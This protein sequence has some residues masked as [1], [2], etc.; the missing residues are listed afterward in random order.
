MARSAKNSTAPCV[1]LV[2]ANFID[3]GKGAWNLLL[4][5]ALFLALATPKARSLSTRGDV[6]LGP[7]LLRVDDHGV[8]LWVEY[9][10][11]LIVTEL[12]ARGRPTGTVA[13]PLPDPE[14]HVLDI[15]PIWSGN[16]IAVFVL[17]QGFSRID[18]PSPYRRLYLMPLTSHAP[19]LVPVAWSM[20]EDGQADGLVGAGV[21]THARRPAVL[22]QKRIAKT[23]HPRQASVLSIVSEGQVTEHLQVGDHLVATSITWPGDGAAIMAGHDDGHP[24]V[25]GSAGQ[26]VLDLPLAARI[27]SVLS[28]ASN[29]P[30]WLAAGIDADGGL[31]VVNRQAANRRGGLVPVPII[32]KTPVVQGFEAEPKPIG[33]PMLLQGAS[34]PWL[35]W[36]THDHGRDGMRILRISPG[37]S[38]ASPSQPAV[39]CPERAHLFGH[40]AAVLP[41]AIVVA[42]ACER[43]GRASV[44]AVALPP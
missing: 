11:T 36:P 37:G 6:L 27:S 12:D 29:S 32:G 26:Y 24:F 20:G 17:E 8:A 9:P 33:R 14:A 3:V 19:L 18:T 5:G 35:A 28:P 38:P 7:K 40:D 13:V 4:L 16:E 43:G 25:M 1:A 15:A 10:G 34:S 22:W 23:G 42:I 21:D 39:S 2:E 30:A 41:S 31:L 44:L